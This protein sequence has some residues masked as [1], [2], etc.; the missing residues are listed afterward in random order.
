MPEQRIPVTETLR[1]LIAFINLELQQKQNELLQLL[2]AS[3]VEQMKLLGISPEDGWRLDYEN[4]EYVK[5][6]SRQDSTEASE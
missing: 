3:S 4:L 6:E 5:V 1:N 2:T